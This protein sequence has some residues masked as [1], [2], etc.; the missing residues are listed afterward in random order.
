MKVRSGA[1][2]PNM[3]GLLFQSRDN[4]GDLRESLQLDVRRAAGDV[5]EMHLHYT[6]FNDKGNSNTR[7]IFLT[8]APEAFDALISLLNSG[9]HMQRREAGKGT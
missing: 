4:A 8:F 9:P 7:H 3:D 5:G 2:M 6:V 1:S